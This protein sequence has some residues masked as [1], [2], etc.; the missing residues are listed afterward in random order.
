MPLF[1]R[2]NSNRPIFGGK[3]NFSFLAG[4]FKNW[5]VNSNTLF[6]GG[7]I[8]IPLSWRELQCVPAM[9]KVGQLRDAKRLI[10][11][12]KTALPVTNS[13]VNCLARCD[14]SVAFFLDVPC[15]K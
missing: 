4:K 15:E 7:K 11:M 8:Q 10:I 1:R 12:Q 13:F 3:F 14:A 5:G 6:N 2:E 9:E